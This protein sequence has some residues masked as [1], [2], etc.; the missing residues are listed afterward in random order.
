[1]HIKTNTETPSHL[2][3]KTTI[4]KTSASDGLGEPLHA[5]VD[6]PSSL[7]EVSMEGLWKLNKHQP[8]THL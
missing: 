2:S 6:Y 3:Q 4:K 7:C 5:Q 8:T 1:M